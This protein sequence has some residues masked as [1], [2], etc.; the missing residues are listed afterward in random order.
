MLVGFCGKM[1]VICMNGNGF[2][3]QWFY[4]ICCGHIYKTFDKANVFMVNSGV[5]FKNNTRYKGFVIRYAQYGKL[6]NNGV[7]FVVGHSMKFFKYRND[8]GLLITCCYIKFF[9]NTNYMIV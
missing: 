5:A 1:L 9:K 3:G 8:L 4:K 7:F 6:P 2:I